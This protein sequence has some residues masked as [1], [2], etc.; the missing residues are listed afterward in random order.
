MRGSTPR[1][2]TT[3]KIAAMKKRLFVAAW[4]ITVMASCSNDD[5]VGEKGLTD[6]S[7]NSQAIAFTTSVP[8][9]T[10]ADATGAEAAGKLRNVF[11]VY[12]IKNE[13]TDGHLSASDNHHLVLNNYKVAW[14]SNS[15]YTTTS[16]TKNWE[17]VGQRMTVWE[18]DRITSSSGAWNNGIDNPQPVKYWDWGADDYTFY[19]FSA[20][21]ND[22]KDGKLEVQK[23][24]YFSEASRSVYD[25]GYHIYI[26]D[27]KQ[28]DLDSLYFS[29]RLFLQKSNDGGNTDRN[30]ENKYGGYVTL[31][32][33]KLA[34]KVRAAMYETIPG[35]SVKID[36]FKVQPRQEGDA[37]EYYS[38]SNMTTVE[39]TDSFAVN[40]YHHRSNSHGSMEIYY[41]DG[42]SVNENNLRPAATDYL[43]PW[44]YVMKLGTNIKT[45]DQIGVSA[46]NPTYDTAG[47]DYTTMFPMAT[48]PHLEL[49]R[50]KVS[51]TL[52]TEGTAKSDDEIKVVDATAEV[53]IRFLQWEPG[54]AYT[55]IFKISDNTNGS[56][57][58]P[59]TDPAG[60]YPITLDAVVA[61]TEEGEQTTLSAVSTPTITVFGYYQ[62]EYTPGSLTYHSGSDLYVVITDADGNVITPE[63]G[64]NV[65]VYDVTTTNAETNPIT[66]AS[67]AEAI[68]TPSSA[69][70]IT[71]VT[72]YVPGSEGIR[73][74]V[75]TPSVVASVPGEDGNDKTIN[76]L[77]LTGVAARYFAIEY[78]YTEDT[79]EKK[80]YLIIHAL[81]TSGVSEDDDDAT[82]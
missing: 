9:M 75:A 47:G 29:E 71:P 6:E 19:A 52:K 11:Y 10:R 20:A 15:A 65:N 35:Y 63:P 41:K 77:K 12:G 57:G 40:C 25:K 44:S 49:L 73:Y 56:T 33:H 58:E 37:V 74:F 70:T 42:A 28:I 3:K 36:G 4:A 43:K 79:E 72:G 55:Y 31:R 14:I 45:A 62:D 60:L 32:F 50:M 26:P 27:D 1:M 22:L 59:G 78:T 64:T 53:P 48:D 61:E 30:A 46:N 66:E 21:H 34:C 7:G 38:F 81:D 80:V 24:A 2:A 17:Y 51:Y 67:V 13:S 5:F 23:M 16:N 18:H 39:P 68:K 54:Y 69:L 82:P 76:A 8:A